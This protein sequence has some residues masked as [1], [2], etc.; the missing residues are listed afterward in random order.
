MSDDEEKEQPLDPPLIEAHMAI[1]HST[2]LAPLSSPSASDAAAYPVTEHSTRIL[3]SSMMMMEPFDE[4]GLDFSMREGAV[5]PF[6]DHR[7]RRLGFAAAIVLHLLVMALVLLAAWLFGIKNLRQLMAGP[8]LQSPPPET[9]Q[10][11]LLQEDDPPP[12]PTLHPEFIIQKLIQPPAPKPIVRPPP[13]PPPPVPIVQHKAS[14]AVPTA[15]KA[16]ASRG[17]LTVVVGS[18]SFPAPIYPAEAQRG[19]IQGTVLVDVLFDG[20]GHVA[21]VSLAQSSGS[22]ILDDAARDT[23]KHD[24]FNVS[25]ANVH[26]SVPIK[27]DLRAGVH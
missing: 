15:M 10:V 3:P 2:D 14:K 13:K 19:R 17:N 8:V 23:I 16:P 24:W 27:F 18:G 4:T 1:S 12:P 6:E 26:A 5:Y 21:S 7:H 22:R 9:I 20:S 25:Y 11:V